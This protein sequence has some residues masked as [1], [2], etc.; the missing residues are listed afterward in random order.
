VRPKDIHKSRA[1]ISLRAI[2]GSEEVISIA[3]GKRL[4]SSFGALHH[5]EI[6]THERKLMRLVGP[7]EQHIVNKSCDMVSGVGEQ[8][9]SS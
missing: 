2:S 6:K 8:A 5:R 1:I 3:P 7:R 9:K 4:M